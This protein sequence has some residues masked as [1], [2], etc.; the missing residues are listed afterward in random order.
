MRFFPRLSTGL[1]TG[2]VDL[3][4]N[5][6]PDGYVPKLPL[7]SGGGLGIELGCGRRKFSA[8]TVG[9]DKWPLTNEE[10]EVVPDIL[11]DL[12]QTPWMWG[13]AE[14]AA[15]VVMHQTLEHIEQII[16][17][18]EEVHRIAAEDAWIEVVV[19]HFRSEGAFQDPTHKRF[20]T[21]GTFHYWEPGFVSTFSDYGIRSHFAICAQDWREDGNIWTVLKP[22]KTPDHYQTWRHWKENVD[23]GNEAPTFAFPTPLDLLDRRDEAHLLGGADAAVQ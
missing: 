9:V 5:P 19:P 10:G 4:Y 6:I 18:M 15:L 21:P 13:E 7:P 14:C 16:P 17:F 22:L 20:F 23:P 11:W 1:S 2:G 12:E 8:D 3:L